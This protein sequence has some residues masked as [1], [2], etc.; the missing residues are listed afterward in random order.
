MATQK[1][2]RRIH[3]VALKRIKAEF[4]AGNTPTQ[5]HQILERELPKENPPIPVPD[6][7]TVQRIVQELQGPRSA[8]WSLVD[9]RDA[10]EAR[11]VLEML[12]ALIIETEDRITSF[13]LREADM[14]LRIKEV[15]RAN[16][17][18]RLVW[19]LAREYLRREDAGQNTRDLDAWLA[20]QPLTMGGKRYREMIKNG[21]E[22]SEFLTRIARERDYEI[23][24]IG[25]PRDKD[26][27][28][29]TY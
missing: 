6:L 3:A 13:S 23:G 26:L 17:G 22:G 7:R 25:G 28:N 9:S 27:Q 24:L 15:D 20:F 29:A 21:W 12:Y 16:L 2:K 10:N 19:Q 1:R 18:P 4:D 11:I 8:A 14:I 5:I